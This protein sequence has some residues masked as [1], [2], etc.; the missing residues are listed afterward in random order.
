MKLQRELTWHLQL[1]RGPRVRRVEAA[2]DAPRR[3]SPACASFDR[4]GTLGPYLGSSA[5]RSDAGRGLARYGPPLLL[6]RAPELPSGRNNSGRYQEEC[7]GCSRSTGGAARVDKGE[8]HSSFWRRAN[9]SASQ[10]VAFAALASGARSSSHPALIGPEMPS[11]A[12]AAFCEAEIPDLSRFGALREGPC[13]ELV[14]KVTDACSSELS[15]G[16][17]R[18][19]RDLQALLMISYLPISR[20]LSLVPVECVAEAAAVPDMSFS[21]PYIAESV[22]LFR[23]LAAESVQSAD[24]QSILFELGQAIVVRSFLRS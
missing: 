3:S 14:R 5:D 13:M 19:L 11:S 1:P 22:A 6:R 8:P 10:V 18:S 12:I 2:Q 9:Q 20:S 15:S 17:R 7:L 23:R 21:D 16:S 24:E 4:F